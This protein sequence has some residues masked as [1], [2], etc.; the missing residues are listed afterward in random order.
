VHN[1]SHELKTCGRQ[2]DEGS[3]TRATS[4]RTPACHK[5]ALNTEKKILGGLLKRRH[6]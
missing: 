2:I 4:R 1:F 5:T 6:S 3:E